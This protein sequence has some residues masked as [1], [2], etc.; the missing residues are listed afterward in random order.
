[1]NVSASEQGIRIHRKRQSELIGRG[2][3]EIP[4]RLDSQSEEGFNG[5]ASGYATAHSFVPAMMQQIAK[6]G[7]K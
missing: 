7:I 1:M 5:I 4:Q 2:R 6:G 3:H